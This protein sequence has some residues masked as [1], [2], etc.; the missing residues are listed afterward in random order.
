MKSAS[1]FA[2]A[3]YGF[4]RTLAHMFDRGEAVTNGTVAGIGDPGAGTTE[5]RLRFGREFQTT[6]VNVR[7]QNGNAH[8]FAFADE[9]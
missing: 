2:L 1:L 4:H 5:C 7:R 8:S 6:L 9:N 3:N